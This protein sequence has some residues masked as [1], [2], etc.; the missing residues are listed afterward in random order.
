RALQRDAGIGASDAEIAEKAGVGRLGDLAWG[1]VRH[2]L[3]VLRQND[4]RVRTYTDV[5]LIG[6]PVPGKGI[7]HSIVATLVGEVP[8]IP[9]PVAIEPHLPEPAPRKADRSEE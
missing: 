4:D 5:P 2:L 8:T 3:V 1:L 9:T 6:H 7:G